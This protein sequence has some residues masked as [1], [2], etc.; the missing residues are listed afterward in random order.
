MWAGQTKAVHQNSLEL[1][2]ETHLEFIML[3]Y[4]VGRERIE[5]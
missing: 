3:G 5:L 4:D 2:N 1:R